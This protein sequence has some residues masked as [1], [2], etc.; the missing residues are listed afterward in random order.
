MVKAKKK[1][2]LVAGIV[3]F[4]AYFFISARPIPLETVL[5]P[6]WLLSLETEIPVYFGDSPSQRSE[7][8]ESSSLIPFE[9]SGRFGFFDREGRFSVNQQ[10]WG[11][12]SLSAHHW[13]EYDAEPAS[14]AINSSSGET[15]SIIED[16]RGYPFFL[17]GRT[18]L[19]N[20]EQN[21]I[22]EIDA[23]GTVRWTYEFSSLLTCVD[24]AAGLLLAGT[25]DG[26][27]GVLDNTGRLV[28]SFEPGGSRYPII[29]GC[30]ISRD[31]SN[32]AIIS[33]INP[34]RFLAL[35]RY[36]TG[37]YRVVYHEFL[38]SDFRR[39][40]YISFIEHDRWVI[41]ERKGG[42][43]VYEIGSRQSGKVAL[44]GELRTIDHSGGQGLVFVIISQ[45]ENTQKLVG[46]R[47]P[48]RVFMKAPFK[49]DDMFLGRSDSQLFV[50][51]RQSIISF[52]LE[53]R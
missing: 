18:F 15:L 44:T 12:V 38:D 17:D 29:V 11:N 13:A 19:I 22:S 33:G 52:D 35:E 7:N 34:Q 51:G 48:G 5:V 6:R 27:T 21:A 39:P 46:I 31:G 25:L 45:A 10:R 14:I 1:L 30:A 28:F 24:A 36:G 2:W 32:L 50:G 4:L 26:Y 47:L 3:F 23:G 42:L 20:S 49:S 9:L 37:E 8:R 41:F 16:P 53:R 43:G 40:V